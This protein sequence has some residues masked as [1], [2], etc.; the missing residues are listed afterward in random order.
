MPEWDLATDRAGW[1]NVA[2]IELSVPSREC[3]AGRI[4]SRQMLEQKI[5][6]WTTER[7]A[8]RSTISWQFTTPAVRIKL[9]RF[10]CVMGRNQD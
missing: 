10:Y 9:R 7:N 1:V 8:L 3:I 6:A 4:E 5:A 2:E